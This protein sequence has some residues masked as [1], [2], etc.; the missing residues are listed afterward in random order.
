MSDILVPVG[1][2]IFIW[3]FSTG[4]ILWLDRL[5][6]TGVR[7]GLVLSSALA[8]SAMFGLAHTAQQTTPTGAY[9][10]FTCTL[11][12]W[13]WHELSFLSGWLTGPRRHALAPG[14]VGW[15]RF[16][17]SVRAILW[18]ELGLLATGAAVLAVTWGAQNTVGIWTYGVLW[19]MRLSAK[20]NLFF[21]VR[22]FSEAFLPVHLKYLQSFFRRRRMNAFFPLAV[23]AA[24][25][26]AVVLVQRALDP[27]LGAGER[28][29]Q[30]LVA[31]L[32]ALAILEHWMLVLPLETTAL[33]RWALA[34][35]DA[36]TAPKE[37]L[38]HAR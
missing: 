33:W 5:P 21:G 19:A 4:L 8:V 29:G 26:L 15:P 18:H 32:L 10:A 2:A 12:I 11:I 27:S 37:T 7:W 28:A 36:T 3:W 24:S 17:Q 16:V 20:L 9:C 34:R 22:N 1:F 38:L 25:V 35:S 13:G 23:G 31:S 14:T 30:W 6:D